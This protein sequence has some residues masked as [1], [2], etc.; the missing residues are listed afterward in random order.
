MDRSL[1]FA[2]TAILGADAVNENK[3][4]SESTRQQAL[5]LESDTGAG[6][7]S[8]PVTNLDKCRRILTDLYNTNAI[9]RKRTRAGVR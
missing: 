5:G 1:R 6:F 4:T 9:P 8:I 3:F 7:V 2:M